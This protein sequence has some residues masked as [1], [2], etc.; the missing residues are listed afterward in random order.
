MGKSFPPLTLFKPMENEKSIT[1]VNPSRP[2]VIKPNAKIVMVR[3]ILQPTVIRPSSVVAILPGPTDVIMIQP[4]RT[5][6]VTLPE[7]GAWDERGWIKHSN[8]GREIYEGYY[9]V[10]TRRYHG[11][12]E[13][14]GR[15]GRNVSA[16]IYNPPP[17]IKHHPHGAC[18][19]LIGDG[20]FI[21]HWARPARNIDDAIL[22]MERVLDESL[23]G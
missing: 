4:S 23:P 16:Y 3:P 5:V 9:A 18:F 17:E 6:T 11:R 22:Y 20:W 19:Q 8:G 12:I 7:R 1:I 2:V 15:R 13:V 14:R 10:G 21:L